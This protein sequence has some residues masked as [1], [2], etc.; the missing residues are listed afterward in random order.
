MNTLRRLFCCVIVLLATSACA[1][2][3]DIIEVAY[4]PE[5]EGKV[6]SGAEA[7]TVALNV[8]DTRTLHRDRV[9]SK[10]NAHGEALAAIVSK[11]DVVKIVTEAFQ[12]ELQRQGFAV[13][14]SPVVVQIDLQK[15]F[16]NFV[17]GFWSGTVSGEVVFAVQV[18]N[19]NLKPFYV[20]RYTGGKDIKGAQIMSG[21]NVKKAIEPAFAI[22]VQ[23]VMTDENFT[24][25]I[26]K[27]NAAIAPDNRRKPDVTAN[28]APMS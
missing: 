3:T 23:K 11:R 17:P 27:A 14:E 16:S 4:N 9:G 24:E 28:A 20:K 19:E 13:G 26:F 6:A 22:A 7:I 25:G 1:R 2:T 21:Y 18:R 5:F 8:E 10:E 15:F 12:E